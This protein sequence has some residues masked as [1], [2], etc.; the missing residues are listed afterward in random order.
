GGGPLH[1]LARRRRGL[2]DRRAEDQGAARLRRKGAGPEVRPPRLPRPRPR[3][4]P[5]AACPAGE[6][7]QGVGG[8][9]EGEVGRV[10]PLPGRASGGGQSFKCSFS[11]SFSPRISRTRDKPTAAS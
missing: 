10:V 7:D 3:Q 8:G 6:A 4:R 9:G 11:S 5:T 1:R 2:Q